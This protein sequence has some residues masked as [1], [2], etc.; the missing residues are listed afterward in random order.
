[1]W[2]VTVA[3]VGCILAVALYIGAM[4]G[5]GWVVQM[6]WNAVCV[7]A[8]GASFLTYWQATGGVFLL[9]I[10]GSFFRSSK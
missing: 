8:F 9:S 7:P 3:F 4:L 2:D 1:M 5:L 6:L 10:I